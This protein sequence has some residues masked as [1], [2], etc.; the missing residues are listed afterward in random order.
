MHA[1]LG[2]IA[3]HVTNILQIKV[4]ISVLKYDWVFAFNKISYPELLIL[5]FTTSQ[6]PSE[7]LLAKSSIVKVYMGTMV[8]LYPIYIGII[9]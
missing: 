3:Y 4:H 5:Y 8:K 9:V 1:S 7:D 2:E 6:I